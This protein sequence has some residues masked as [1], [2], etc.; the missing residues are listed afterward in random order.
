MKVKGDSG[1]DKVNKIIALD[2]AITYTFYT[3]PYSDQ[4]LDNFDS[5]F[6]SLFKNASH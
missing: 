3:T 6:V 4:P 5:E 2:Y 1:K